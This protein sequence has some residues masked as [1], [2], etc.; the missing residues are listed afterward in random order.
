MANDTFCIEGYDFAIT[1]FDTLAEA[2]AA[3]DLTET[4]MAGDGYEYVAWAQAAPKPAAGKFVAMY[5]RIGSSHF[6]YL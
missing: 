3:A 4:E 6:I 2:Q 5:R 1:A